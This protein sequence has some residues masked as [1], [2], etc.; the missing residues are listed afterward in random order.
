MPYEIGLEA[1]AG[2][3]AI[4]NAEE[5][6]AARQ[7]AGTLWRKFPTA[8]LQ[9]ELE[10]F[11]TDCFSL[12]SYTFVSGR[13]RDAMAANSYVQYFD[14]DDSFSSSAVRSMQYKIMNVAAIENISD[15]DKSV[16]S[17]LDIGGGAPPIRSN[18]RSIYIRNN[19][20][21][22]HEIFCDETFRSHLFCTDALALRVLKRDCTGI[23][24]FD[25]SEM[26]IL[27]PKRFRTLRG[28]EQSGDYDPIRKV[29]YTTLVEVL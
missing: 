13:M 15:P 29:E 3:A 1:L 18:I 23:R 26:S 24:F 17:W 12:E 27:K 4:L 9:I 16:F 7:A 28:V 11:S 2:H 5:V 20:D 22:D 8:K 14:I 25:P 21:V 10:S 19:C 6:C